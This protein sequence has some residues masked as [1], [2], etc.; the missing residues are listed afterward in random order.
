VSVK[1]ARTAF[2]PLEVIDLGALVTE[3]LPQRTWGKALLKRLGFKRQNAFEAVRWSFA[4]KEG[5]I[6]GSNSYYTLF[7]HGGPHVDAPN[8]VGESGGLDSYP[9][10]A[11]TGPLKVFDAS[12]YPHGRSVPMG[13]FKNKVKTGD[14]VMVFTGYEPPRTDS[15]LPQVT[16][17]ASDAA[18]FLVN[19]PVR[20]YGT[21]A[22]GVDDPADTNSP[23]IHQFF[24]S[25]S[26][27]VYEQLCNLDQLVGREKM[28]FVGVPLNI[29]D[30]DG[31]LVRPVALIY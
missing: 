15:A 22:F 14:V 5:E 17:L 29:K 30:G 24:L 16:T 3:D 1:E 9:I 25:R 18:E 13:L 2:S 20:A 31:M 7:N 19:L 27:P 10:H 12:K 6:S 4:G 11:F 8:H 28:F 23:W 21:D 26:I